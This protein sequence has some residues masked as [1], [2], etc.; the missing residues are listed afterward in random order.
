MTPS[1][2]GDASVSFHKQ[3]S[4]FNH[5]G[6]VI[7]KPRAFTSGARDLGAP[8]TLGTGDP[9]L[10]LKTCPAQDAVNGKWPGGPSISC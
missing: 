9:S 2:Q 8:L 6:S 7:P 3:Q 10:H 1:G 4:K 5:P